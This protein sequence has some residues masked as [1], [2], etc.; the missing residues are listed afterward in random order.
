MNLRPAW[1]RDTAGCCLH[2]LAESDFIT[3]GHTQFA[4]VKMIEG[5][6][7]FFFQYSN[8]TKD[9]LDN[10]NFSLQA[11]KAPDQREAKIHSGFLAQFMQV[12]VAVVEADLY[13][14][15]SLGAALATI[16]G[17]YWRKPVIA[18][19]S[20]RVGD[21]TFAEQADSYILRVSNKGDPVTHLPAWWQGYRHAGQEVKMT[22]RKR[23][24]FGWLFGDWEVHLPGNYARSIN[25][26]WEGCP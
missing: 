9:W 26:A 6:R 16:A 22:P 18:M 21:K 5:K 15:H 12:R 11:T 20:P 19:A 23:N 25:A 14:G 7:A 24:L 2:F 4:R 3:I 8:D 1:N 17:W 10:L 13:I